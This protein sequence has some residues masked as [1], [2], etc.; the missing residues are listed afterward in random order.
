MTDLADLL[1]ATRGKKAKRRQMLSGYLL[2][3]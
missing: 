3:E 2:T 1:H